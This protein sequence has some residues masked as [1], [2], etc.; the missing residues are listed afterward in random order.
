MSRG[1]RVGV[2]V[3]VRV[4][5][6]VLLIFMLL[7]LLLDLFKLL[8]LLLVVLQNAD[9]ALQNDVKLVTAIALVHHELTLVHALDPAVLQDL[10]EEV[11][12]QLDIALSLVL[13]I[14]C[15][16]RAERFEVGN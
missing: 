10:D 11:L 12:R 14:Q 8:R 4:R 7:F 2:G 6:R 13:V 5:V 9:C 16:D 15:F 1:G 3:R